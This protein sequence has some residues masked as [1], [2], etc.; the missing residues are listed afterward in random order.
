MYEFEATLWR[1]RE[2][3]AWHFVTLPED[4]ADDIDDRTPV[5]A[6]FG[7]VKVEV[8]VGSQT[9]STSVF[10]SKEQRSFVLPIKKAVREAAGCSE[11]D[12]IHV[13][14]AVQS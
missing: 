5:R 2:D 10:P 14:L 13:G 12:R 3:G 1:W 8:T 11:G 7:S 9:W 4:V 6:G